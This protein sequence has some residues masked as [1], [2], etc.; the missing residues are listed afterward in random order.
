MEVSNLLLAHPN[1]RLQTASDAHLQS[2]RHRTNPAE[3]MGDGMIGAEMHQGSPVRSSHA[4]M[5]PAPYFPPPTGKNVTFELL[6]PESPQHRARLPMR[7]NIY[8]HDTTDSIITTVKNFYGLYEGKGVSFEDREGNTLIARYEN[9]GNNMV[10][11]VRALPDELEAACQVGQLAHDGRSPKK[12]RL[13]EP[14]QM[15]PPNPASRPSS[16]MARKRSVSPTSAG[17]RRSASAG[18]T[19]KARSRPGLRT[20]GPSSFE[21]QVDTTADAANGY[22]GYSDSDGGS[23]SATSSR[24]ARNEQLASAEISLDNIVEGG[25]RKRAKF[26]S[27]VSSCC[28]YEMFARV[29]RILMGRKMAG[30][31]P[32]CASPSAH[33]NIHLF[34]FSASPG[35]QP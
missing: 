33:N 7:V 34:G 11:Y 4:V 18:T 16:R 6:L 29:L 27:S 19:T 26:D 24:R 21:S 5:P 9:F 30:A 14:F 31:S 12:P 2:P 20:R 25:R 17:G 23:V 35:R 32:V 13:D 10:V 22:H 8:P 15:L 1:S 28:A 3:L